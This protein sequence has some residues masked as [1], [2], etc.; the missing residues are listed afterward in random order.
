MIFQVA[1]MTPARS[2]TIVVRA[3]ASIRRSLPAGQ[4][5]EQRHNARSHSVRKTRNKLLF[6]E[7]SVLRIAYIACRSTIELGRRGSRATARSYQLNAAVEAPSTRDSKNPHGEVRK[8]ASADC[9]HRPPSTTMIDLCP[10]G[11]SQRYVHAE[12]FEISPTSAIFG[13]ALVV[14]AGYLTGRSCR[15]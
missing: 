9:R 8:A 10:R 12:R 2:R 4:H 5:H 6:S 3:A 11:G 15:G 14:P 7:N 13:Q 1:R